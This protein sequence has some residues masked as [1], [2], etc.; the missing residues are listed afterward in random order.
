[1]EL[2][3]AE[4][5]PARAVRPAV[6]VR[7]RLDARRRRDGVR[8]RRHRDAPRR[9]R[10][11]RAGRQVARRARRAVEGGRTRYRLLETLRQY[12]RDRLRETGEA[13]AV[14]DAHLSWAVGLAEEAERHLD[15][16]EQAAWLDR[17]R[18]RAGQPAGRA[19]VGD[20]LPQRRSGPAPCLDHDRQPVDVAF[21][22]A[23]RASG[24]CSGCWRHR[25]RL[26]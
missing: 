9:R 26:P 25:P 20:Q 15:G 13:A 4:R 3:A 1:M 10:S 7:R 21:A 19:G 6:G 11:G 5:A 12:G 24:G 16:L 2:R 18:E 8:L 22:R 17:P 14:R 23:R